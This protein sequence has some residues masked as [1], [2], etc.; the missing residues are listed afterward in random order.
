MIIR[1]IGDEKQKMYWFPFCFIVFAVRRG[2]VQT[3]F[4][5]DKMGFVRARVLRGVRRPGL[6]QIVR[7]RKRSGRDRER[8]RRRQYVYTGTTPRRRIHRLRYRIRVSPGNHIVLRIFR[9]DS[10]AFHTRY[11]YADEFRD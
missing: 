5:H 2:E 8:I 6:P 10:T 3:A 1:K 4:G 9:F 7:K 11:Y